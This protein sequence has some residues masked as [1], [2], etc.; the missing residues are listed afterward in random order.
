MA[1]TTATK[2]RLKDRVPDAEVQEQALISALTMVE[3]FALYFVVCDPA[4][5][6]PEL[7]ETV[8]TG[9]APKTVQRVPVTRETRNLLYLLQETLTDPLPDIIFVYGLENWISGAAEPRSVPFLLNLNAARNHFYHRIPRPIVFFIPVHVM[10]AIINGAPDFFS[11]RSGAYTFPMTD[12]ERRELHTELTARNFT[13]TVGIPWQAKED[14]IHRT[15]N[16]L[17]TYRS[18]P[19]SEQNPQDIALLCDSLATL[20]GTAGRYAEAE[21]LYREALAIRREALPQGHPDIAQSLNNLAELYRVTGRYGE[22]EP[23]YREALDIYREAL[24][25]AHPNVATSLNNLAALLESTGRYGEA[26][27]LYREALAIRQKALPSGHPSIAGSLNNLALLLESTG[28]Y[29]EAEPLYREALAIVRE[30]LGDAHPHVAMSLNNLA[31]LL[32][33]TGRYAEALPLLVEALEIMVA[34]LGAN[35]P[36][37]MVVSRNLQGLRE[38]MQARGE[39]PSGF[40]EAKKVT[41][42][43][44]PVADSGVAKR[45]KGSG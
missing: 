30:A 4:R 6:R 31:A 32:R 5:K 29:G 11:V 40:G 8:T 25:D 37:T 3:G 28:R 13:D 7:M 44:L 17:A 12:D 23:L 27:P 39:S 42:G 38:E 15:E 24:G 45:R 9:V 20:Y 43:I 36:N 35:H 1:E 14:E 41:D 22:A 10:N 33:S 34:V 21:P 26:E 2:P 19:P 18:L 16:L